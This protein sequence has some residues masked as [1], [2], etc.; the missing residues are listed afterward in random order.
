MYSS[1]QFYC[2][3]FLHVDCILATKFIAAFLYKCVRFFFENFQFAKLVLLSQSSRTDPSFHVGQPDSPTLLGWGKK[4]SKESHRAANTWVLEDG[5][6]A[7]MISKTIGSIENKPRPVYCFLWCRSC[8][9][10]TKRRSSALFAERCHNASDRLKKIP[11]DQLPFRICSKICS[12]SCW[13]MMLWES[14]QRH[15]QC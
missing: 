13:A 1:Y 11:F 10:T 15:L 12:I 3:F 2:L 9:Q 5:K 6:H 4:A 8:Q 7:N 14:L